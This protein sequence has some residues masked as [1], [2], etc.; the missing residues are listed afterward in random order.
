MILGLIIITIATFF[1]I[2][3]KKI[4][5]F[6]SF[7]GVIAGVCFS[8][9]IKN[10]AITNIVLDLVISFCLAYPLFY[11][12]VLGAGDVKILIVISLFLT[13]YSWL[14]L[15][16]ISITLAATIYG[17][18]LFKD[19]SFDLKNCHHYRFTHFILLAYLILLN[20]F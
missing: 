8:I 11:F 5:N 17:I 1:D 16:I 14:M 20:F 3:T 19:K 2:R 7:L 9:S 6:F 4:P 12:N 10:I 15:I 18:R 13:H